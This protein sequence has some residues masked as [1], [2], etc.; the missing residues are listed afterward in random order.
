RTCSGRRSTPEEPVMPRRPFAL[1]AACLCS[2]TLALPF[3]AAPA[4]AQDRPRTL[5]TDGEQAFLRQQAIAKQRFNSINKA[6]D[7]E[8][9]SKDSKEDQGAIDVMAQYY[10]YRLTW[11]LNTTAGEVNKLWDE[12]TS[13]VNN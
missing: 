1:L 3:L 7:S 12:F 4:W 9:A 2:I 10:T 5:P 6:N 13:Q 8:K 11:D